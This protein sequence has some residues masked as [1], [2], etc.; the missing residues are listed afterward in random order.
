MLINFILFMLKK[1]TDIIRNLGLFLPFHVF[2]LFH[3]TI[4]LYCTTVTMRMRRSNFHGDGKVDDG[5]A[6]WYVKELMIGV[7]GVEKSYVHGRYIQRAIMSVK[8]C[9][10]I[11]FATPLWHVTYCPIF[12][13]YSKDSIFRFGLSIKRKNHQL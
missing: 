9:S 3:I 1:N 4:I 8:L 13:S 2:F 12:A 10:S 5:N 7:W 11:S 6:L